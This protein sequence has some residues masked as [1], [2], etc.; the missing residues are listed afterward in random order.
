MSSNAL[1]IGGAVMMKQAMHFFC[2][3]LLIVLPGC[4]RSNNYGCRSV[5]GS[6]TG[7]AA[8]T[9]NETASDVKATTE[10]NAG[11]SADVKVDTEAKVNVKAKGDK[12]DKTI[13]DHSDT[14][15]MDLSD[16][17]ITNVVRRL[18]VAYWHTSH[19]S[20]IISGMDAM[21]LLDARF[22]HSVKGATGLRMDTSV[23]NY[24]KPCADLSHCSDSGAMIDDTVRILTEYPDINVVMWAWC[25][26]GGH[27]VE[28]YLSNMET[29][30]SRFGPGGTDPRA[31][32]TPVTFI[33]MTAH[34]EGT[35]VFPRTAA[36]KIRAHCERK[37]RWLI[38]YFDIESYDIIGNSYAN[39][40][41]QDNLN[42][43]GGNWAVEYLQSKGANPK[44]KSLV[45][46]TRNCSHSDNPAEAKLNCVLKAQAFW[47]ALAQIAG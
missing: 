18:K 47:N 5:P 24:G 33:F 36:A 11:A 46:V 7:T 39:R 32:K 34:S 8:G 44:L 20:Q 10:N 26:I 15:A 41:I 35:N 9:S 38:D 28:K 31:A 27:K 19:G 17:A 40:N 43:D 29:L 2:I 45:N 13:F 21:A 16:E 25:S 23:G 4:F 42:Y 22:A 1:L 30:I 6:T 3:F 37:G 12:A 14:Y